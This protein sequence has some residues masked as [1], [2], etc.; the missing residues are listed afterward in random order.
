MSVREKVGKLKATGS[1]E[2]KRMK[3]AQVLD[4]K[5]IQTSE[6][7]CKSLLNISAQ[8]LSIKS[9]E[10]YFISFRNNRTSV[11]SLNI[12]QEYR[13]SLILFFFTRCQVFVF[14]LIT[15]YLFMM[16]L[17]CGIDILIQIMKF[18][19]FHRLIIVKV[20]VK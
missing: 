5:V 13:T 10:P 4:E 14:I 15:T 9:I 1:G 6:S 19:I 11:C 7:Y 20:R 2:I 18:Y 17:N 12:S 16:L 3:Q 8:C